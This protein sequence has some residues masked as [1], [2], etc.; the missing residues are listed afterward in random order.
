MPPL[1]RDLFKRD[2][3]DFDE[4][5]TSFDAEMAT[6]VEI[7]E[8]AVVDALDTFDPECLDAKARDSLAA[9]VGESVK[10]KI[11]RSLVVGLQVLQRFGK[12]SESNPD[13]N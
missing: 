4:L 1:P 10:P 6:F 7:V 11:A 5:R 8:K 12:E 9:M 2:P 3:D 13:A